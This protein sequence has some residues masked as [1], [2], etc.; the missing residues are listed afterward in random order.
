M[1]KLWSTKELLIWDEREIL[2]WNHRLNHCYFK[3]LLILS[4]MG[5]TPRNISKIRKLPPCV[6][7]IFGKSHKR[8]WSTKGKHSG[9]P[10]RK[11]LD[12]RPGAMTSIEQIVSAQPGIIPQV[13]GYL[14]HERFWTSNIFVDH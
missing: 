5:I 12:T 2:I 14:T 6:A 1:A 10:I 9:R 7:C 13:T 4:N 11:P 8:P 3:S